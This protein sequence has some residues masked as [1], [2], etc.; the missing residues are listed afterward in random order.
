MHAEVTDLLDLADSNKAAADAATEHR[1]YLAE[2]I[3]ITNQNL[4]WII[5]RRASIIARKAE[6][7]E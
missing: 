4:V 7:A 5:A 6:L 2:Q 3:D 1:K